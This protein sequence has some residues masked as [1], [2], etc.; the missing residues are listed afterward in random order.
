MFG[1]DKHKSPRGGHAVETLIGP[2]AVIRGDIAFSGGLYVE[3]TIH[4]KVTAEDGTAAVITIADNGHIEGEVRA[5][6]V[7]INGRMTGDVHAGERIELAAHARVSGNV[8]YKV[9][10]M[11][12]GAV[13]TGRLIHADAPMAQLT[14]PEPAV[15][16]RLK[17]KAEA[18]EA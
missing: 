16:A 1:N 8:H 6:V 14:G 13:I 15:V 2:H 7:V 11:A 4:G 12:A 5:P 3:G 10:E 17:T 9:V 18:Q